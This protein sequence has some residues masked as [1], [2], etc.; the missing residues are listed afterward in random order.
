MDLLQSSDTAKYA[1]GILGAALTAKIISKSLERKQ[2]PL[3][4]GPKPLPV[5]GNLLDLPT[6]NVLEG[7]FW[8][9]HKELYGMYRKCIYKRFLDLIAIII[10]PISS[11]TVLG[12]KIII[13]NDVKIALDLMDK[14]SSIYSNRPILTFGGEMYV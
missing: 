8:A 2:L 9:K 10:G 13:V 11:I 3:P 7:P 12:Q 5:L 1:L 6:A 4:P 14:R